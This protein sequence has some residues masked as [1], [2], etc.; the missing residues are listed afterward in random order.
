MLSPCMPALPSELVPPL[1][2]WYR[3]HARDLP[4]RQDPSPYRVL[5][6]ELMC[7][8]T[9]VQTALPYFERFVA[10]WP[11]LDALASASED[12]VLGAWAGLGY[13]RRARSLHAAV[14][15]ARDLGG[16][17]PTEDGLRALPGI[18]P[19]TAGAIASIAFGL[20]AAAVDGNVERVLSRLDR[21]PESPWTA[22]G[23]RHLQQRARSLHGGRGPTDHAG[24]LTQALMELGAR[25]CTPKSPDC[26]SCPVA[27]SCEARTHGAQTVWPR[28]RP[29]KAPTPIA[30]AV[31]LI[32]DGGRILFGR[33]SPGGLLGG[34]WEPVMVPVGALAEAT[35]Q[36]LAVGA[37]Q[38]I[39]LEVAVGPHLG[40]VVHVFSHRKLT[41]H[42]FAA[43]PLGASLPLPPGPE[44]YADARWAAPGDEPALSTLAR[45]L[46]ALR[47]PPPLLLAA[48]P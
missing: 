19:Y 33:R 36:S 18:G 6:S 29:R 12:D 46:L 47:P 24:D 14:L 43:T 13:Y 3:A 38:R 30:A 15:A 37:P 26:G 5:L 16:L 39:G 27:T 17:P 21:S 25:V 32:E 40:T 1:L 23:K 4:W 11:T 10:R 9:R 35:A 34:L 48:E 7:Q 28:A 2:D 8:Q 41:A 45:K 22:A 44:A 42:V 20:P 31:G